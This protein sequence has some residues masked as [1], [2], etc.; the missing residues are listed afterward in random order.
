MIE[1]NLKGIADLR[2]RVA[3]ILDEGLIEHSVETQDVI[4]QLY[5]PNDHADQT[6]VDL[7]Q[8]NLLDAGPNRPRLH[9]KILASVL[10]ILRMG[11]VES[12]LVVGCRGCFYASPPKSLVLRPSS[13]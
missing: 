6:I 12:L 7:M 8:R 13:A 11:R 10:A 2:G 1:F 9:V 4:R 3:N 5:G